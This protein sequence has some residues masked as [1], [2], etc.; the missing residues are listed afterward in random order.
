MNLLVSQVQAGVLI[1]RLL[2]QVRQ[3]RRMPH[4]ALPLTPSSP[5]QKPSTVLLIHP[6]NNTCP[7]HKPPRRTYHHHS[8]LPCLSPPAHAH[9]PSQAIPAVQA[10]RRTRRTPTLT[11]KTKASR[12]TIRCYHGGLPTTAIR[13][14]TATAT[15][16]LAVG[17]HYQTPSPR[18]SPARSR[19]KSKTD[20]NEKKNG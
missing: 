6:R 4:R 10:T 15:I 19:R 20:R 8:F 2:C 16:R 3:L 9:P 18:P 5:G 13:T 1:R 7:S 14:A 11:Q 17:S 12:L